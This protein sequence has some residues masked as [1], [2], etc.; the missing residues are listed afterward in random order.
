MNDVKS[1]NPHQP[2][3][4]QA[5]AEVAHSV[6][7]LIGENRDYRQ[8]RILERLAEPDRVIVFRVTWEDGDGNVRVNRAWRVQFNRSI[9]PY[10][11]G[12]RFQKNVTMSVLK[13]LGF[14]QTFK[15]SLTGLPMGGAKGG[16]NF[17]PK[18][19]SSREVMR[20]CQSFMTELFRHIGAD[21]DVPAGDIG[22]GTREI[23][24]LF[25]QYMRLSNQYE[26][27]MTGKGLA[28]GGSA[29]REEATGY[30][31]V[32]FLD[33]ML[34]RR[35]ESLA[36]KRI[37]ISGAGNVALFA[38]E[39]A[40]R[41]GGK[42][43]TLSDSSGFVRC[44]D[45]LDEERLSTIKRVKLDER[46]SLRQLGEDLTGVEYEEGAKPWGVPC[47]VA[48]P[49]ATQNELNGEDAKALLVNGV[50]AIVEGAN[51]PS[52]DA[53][54]ELFRGAGILFAPGK[55]ANAGGVT[56]SGFEQSQNSLRMRWERDEVDSR[57]RRIM[58]D[59]HE[60]CVAEMERDGGGLD[61]ADAA[62]RASFRRVADAMVAQGLS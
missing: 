46:G 32:Y 62:N 57:L 40:I 10:K 41:D 18:G 45:G 42:V 43:V 58:R 20:F 6:F 35:D 38:A 59:I 16:S 48:M 28:Y 55:A 14:E 31:A 11:G 39:R 9:G 1:R 26:G 56:V 17:D 4:I 13:F 30:G 33:S 29:I 47:D 25:G 15:N 61:Y 8:G 51:M 37:A 21:A 49:C 36:G 52:T 22:V 24:F 5:V 7:P 2:E 50:E 23:G 3:F 27:A 19:K 34:E 60:K 54:I 12:L 53:A 44:E